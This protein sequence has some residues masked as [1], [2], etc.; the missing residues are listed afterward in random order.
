[1]ADNVFLIPS[2]ITL[3]ATATACFGSGSVIVLY[4]LQLIAFLIPPLAFDIRGN[5][6]L[7]A[8]ELWSPCCATGP[9]IAPATAALISSSAI[10]AP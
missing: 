8:S 10:A 4:H 1:M 3:L 9:D 7:C 5:G 2:L 6:L